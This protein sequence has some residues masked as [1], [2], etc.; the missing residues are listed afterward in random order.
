MNH[1]LDVKR[2]REKLK[3]LEIY[4]MPDFFSRRSV[5]D[6]SGNPRAWEAEEM[7]KAEADLTDEFQ[8]DPPEFAVAQHATEEDEGG[9]A[10]AQNGGWGDVPAPAELVKALMQEDADDC[11]EVLEAGIWD[12]VRQHAGLADKERHLLSY[13]RDAKRRQVDDTRYAKERRQRMSWEAL[14]LR[15]RQQ[16]D[17]RYKRYHQRENA[18]FELESVRHKKEVIMRSVDEK[19][20]LMGTMGTLSALFAGLTMVAMVEYEVPAS[21]PGWLQCVFGVL[22]ALTLGCF[23]ITCM[24]VICLHIR[25]VHEF[26]NANSSFR[27]DLTATTSLTQVP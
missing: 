27:E 9:R 6:G 16:D 7:K 14:Q 5:T 17:Q 10:A 13:I 3:M 12:F 26:G 21:A 22:T 23:T 1:V 2:E 11:A 20:Q 4:T 25:M 19:A 18:E 24:Y 8:L 15:L